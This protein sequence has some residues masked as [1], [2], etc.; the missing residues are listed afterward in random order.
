MVKLAPSI[1]SADFLNLGNAVAFVNGNAD[2]FHM[3]VMD[4]VQVPNISFGFPVVEAVARKAEKPLDIHLMIS[5][6]E[7]YALKFARIKG[8]GMVSF[9]LEASERPRELLE[10]LRAEGVKAG[11]A[12]NPDCPPESLFQ[13]LDACD[14][15]LVMG[16][17][18]GF[19]GQKF[20]PE[21]VGRVALVR[22]EILRR[23]L[24]VFIEV[25]GGV[26]PSNAVELTAAGAE[27]LV[28]ASAI[29]NSA[30]P[31]SAAKEFYRNSPFPVR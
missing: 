28:A 29:F 6:P 19:S 31:A 21:T 10:A 7:R 1:L 25:D 22:D 4:G 12:I 14:F 18:A 15:V 24:P 20:I 9:H 17:Y 3:D 5:S 26:N 27:V 30:D 8:V 11:L 2:I 13:Y 23:G 16:V